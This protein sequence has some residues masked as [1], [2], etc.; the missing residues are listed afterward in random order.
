[1]VAQTSSDRTAVLLETLR[2]ASDVLRA[3]PERHADVA[4]V[5]RS[6]YE[7]AQRMAPDP[8]SAQ[9]GRFSR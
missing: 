3:T 6:E 1:M 5:C 9:Q 2:W 7:R 8:P 4:N